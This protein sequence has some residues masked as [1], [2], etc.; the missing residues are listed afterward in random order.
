MAYTQL[1]IFKLTYDSKGVSLFNCFTR[2]YIHPRILLWVLCVLRFLRE[3]PA[4]AALVRSG[5]D[6]QLSELEG[7]EN[8]LAV[9]L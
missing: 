9:V 3:P 8:G 5:D 6:S 4:A 2:D 7:G 1:L